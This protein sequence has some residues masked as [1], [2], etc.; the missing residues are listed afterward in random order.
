MTSLGKRII[1]G[2]LAAVFAA[3]SAGCSFNPLGG[4]G[5]KAVEV[6]NV[7]EMNGYLYYG[8]SEDESHTGTVS[9]DFV[10]QVIVDTSMTVEKIFVKEGDIV[11]KGSKL[12][13]YNMESEEL[14]L[15]LEELEI[16]LQEQ[17]L[18]K[19]QA[20]LEKLKNTRTVPDSTTQA[21]DNDTSNSSKSTTKKNDTDT[22]TGIDSTDS[23]DDDSGTD[24][25]LDG[26]RNEPWYSSLNLQAGIKN[27]LSMDIHAEESAIKPT[28]FDTSNPDYI[29]YQENAGKNTESGLPVRFYLLGSKGNEASI[30]GSILK[31]FCG[32][33]ATYIFYQCATQEDLD[34]RK[35]DDSL[36]LTINGNNQK[37]IMDET[38][39]DENMYPIN[40]IRQHQKVLGSF[41]LS[42]ADDM[43]K[44]GKV[45]QGNIHH[46]YTSATYSDGTKIQGIKVVYAVANNTSASTRISE[47]GVLTVGAD[48][49]I[50]NTLIVSANLN[51]HVKRLELTVIKDDINNQVEED[52][53]EMLDY[54]AANSDVHTV[55]G[56]NGSSGNGTSSNS[57]D[58]DSSSGIDDVPDDNRP[59]VSML[60]E[61]IQEKEEEIWET[62]K[63]IA[64][65]KIKYKEDK[66]KIA[67]ATIKAKFKGTVTKS[68]T[69]D[70]IPTDNS[71]AIIVKAKTGM[72]VH[73]VV[74]EMELDDVQ[75][76]GKISCKSWANS[77]T[78][79]AEITEISP[80]PISGD[81]S[82]YAY[83]M[84]AAN[85]NSSYYPVTAYVEEAEGLNSGDQVYVLFD[86]V[87]MGK[88]QSGLYLEKKY[89][90]SD[91]GS[92]YVYKRGKDKRLHKQNVQVG[93]SVEE[94]YEILSGL[95]DDDYIAF[96]YPD[97]DMVEGAETEI[98]EASTDDGYGAY[99]Y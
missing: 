19:L 33:S 35:Y 65:G 93:K 25:E 72:F 34:N 17:K 30:K 5:K 80:Y 97:K 37:T 91:G 40:I 2:V 55:V 87:S 6:R 32:S 24:S 26:R 56:D 50:N 10:Q 9:S 39:I 60:K 99:D 12:L 1:V 27:L 11:K 57:S 53:N 68:C 98:V 47:N 76:G 15:K 45:G 89:V 49:K 54:G 18:K 64:E 83:S 66:A 16:Q 31:T 51:G 23:D 82:D 36:T 38:V 63:A 21:E 94:Y 69:L 70:T 28:Q 13:K 61:E 75:V 95:T 44:N 8:E 84:T 73:F 85:P 46:F 14:D 42:G 92:Y 77:E 58:R 62:Q 29:K 3:G 52:E 71:P 48:E 90:R 78:Y 4:G 74:N 81:S 22:G 7:G 86:S 41:T 88:T 43:V 67:K 79:D 96:P 20:E 59:T